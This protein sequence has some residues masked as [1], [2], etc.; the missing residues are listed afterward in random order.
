MQEVTAANERG[1]ARRTFQSL[2]HRNFRLFFFGQLVSNSGNWL[3]IVALTLL[4]LHRTQRGW[5]V[6]VL[7]ACQF[8]PILVLS[9]FAGLIADRSAKRRLLYVTQSLEMAQ[10]FVLAALAFSS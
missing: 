9:P 8:G 5:A 7:S 6:G 10:S 4:V 1:L 3:T 2:W